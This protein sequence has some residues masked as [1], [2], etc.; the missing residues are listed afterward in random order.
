MSQ[1]KRKHSR[2]KFYANNRSRPPSVSLRNH[3]FVTP[4]NTKIINRDYA[5]WVRFLAL[6][7][8]GLGEA[9]PSH[10]PYVWK[11]NMYT[12]LY[13]IGWWRTSNKNETVRYTYSHLGRAFRTIAR[14]LQRSRRDFFSAATRFHVSLPRNSRGTQESDQDR[15]GTTWYDTRRRRR[16]PRIV[17]A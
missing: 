16:R 12:I 10:D 15:C 17:E 6:L 8:G 7:A 9:S 3:Y 2:V 13:D 5:Q 1:L 14:A 11:V 4:I